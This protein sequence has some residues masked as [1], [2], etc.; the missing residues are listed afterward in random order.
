MSRHFQ[1]VFGRTE[2]NLDLRLKIGHLEKGMHI[3][4]ELGILRN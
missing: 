3:F 2:C 1:S 4:M